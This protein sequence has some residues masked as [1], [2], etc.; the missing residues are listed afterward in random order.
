MKRKHV[1]L[2]GEKQVGKST[3]LAKVMDELA[4]EP[5]GF[6]TR[7][8]YIEN[9][10]KGH[11]MHSLIPCEENDIPISLRHRKDA[12][13]P[14]L[15]SF[16]GFGTTILRHSRSQNTAWILMDELGVLEEGA[17]AFQAEV[18]ACLDG[19]HRVLGVIKQADTPWLNQIRMRKDCSIFELTRNNRVEIYNELISM[20]K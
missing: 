17:P 14:I 5:T 8:Y 10:I 13:L 6:I 1:F 19:E 2:T 3:L 7:P 16:D 15:A 12:S 18:L 11:Y 4:I 20:L 9:R